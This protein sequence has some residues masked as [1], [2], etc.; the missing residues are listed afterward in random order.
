M[1]GLLLAAKM[2]PAKGWIVLIIFTILVMVALV[3]VFEF[4]TEL[5]RWAISTIYGSI[6]IIISFVVWGVK[7]SGK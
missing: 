2:V 4:A 7:A 6:I 3:F 5:P 1:S